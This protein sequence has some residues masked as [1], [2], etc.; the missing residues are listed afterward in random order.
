LRHNLQ[1]AA[2]LRATRRQVQHL[3][4][5]FDQRRGHGEFLRQAQE[6]LVELLGEGQQA[7]AWVL[8]QAADETNLVR[9]CEMQFK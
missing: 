5:F 2:T 8:Q 4:D 1:K 6:I 9:R 3:A 7:I